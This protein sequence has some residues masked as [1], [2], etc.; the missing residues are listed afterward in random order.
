MVLVHLILEMLAYTKISIFTIG[1]LRDFTIL[2]W[3]KNLSVG[4]RENG[5][6]Q[7]VLNREF[8]LMK[9]QLK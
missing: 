3:N 1:F 2:M 9:Q 6:A 7:S 8:F 4:G 5:I